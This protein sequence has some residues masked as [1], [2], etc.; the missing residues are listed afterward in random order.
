MTA[1]EL[2]VENEWSNLRKSIGITERGKLQKRMTGGSI[3]EA[4]H[5]SSSKYLGGLAGA[6]FSDDDH[7]VILANGSHVIFSKTIER[8]A[9]L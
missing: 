3:R 8:Q 5:A 7:D 1:A 6:G 4:E 2:A 9:R